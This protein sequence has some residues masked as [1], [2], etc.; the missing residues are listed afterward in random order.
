M[1]ASRFCENCGATLVAKAR[2]CEAC[3]RAV[4]APPAL[5][6]TGVVAPSSATP[7]PSQRRWLIVGG[8]GGCGGNRLR[9]RVRS[10]RILPLPIH[11]PGTRPYQHQSLFGSRSAPTPLVNTS[12]FPLT[13]AIAAATPTIPAQGRRPD[14]SQHTVRSPSAV[15]SIKA[16]WCRSIRVKR[17]RTARPLSMPTGRTAALFPIRLSITTG[18]GM[19]P[20]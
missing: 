7:R 1:S 10:G 4:F 9:G 15:R 2:F 13:P 19:G 8:V 16:R 14:L 12:P 20:T 17:F 18:T 6:V 11:C 3:G 5:T